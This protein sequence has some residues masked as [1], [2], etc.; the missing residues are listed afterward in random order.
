MNWINIFGLIIVALMLL[1]NMIYFYINNESENKCKNMVMNILEQIG[2]Y[3]SMFLMVINIGIYEFGFHSDEAFAAW[4]LVSVTL[5]SLYWMFWF[6]YFK[7]P[8]AFFSIMLAVIPSII[9][10]SSGFF[11]RHWLLVLFGLIFSVSHIYVTYKNT[12]YK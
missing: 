12:F 3:G 8:R 4:L 2:R 5:I 6:L 9:F 10:V 7:T 1:P 11:L